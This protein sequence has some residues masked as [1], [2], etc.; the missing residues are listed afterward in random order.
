MDFSAPITILLMPWGRVGSNMVNRIAVESRRVKVFNEPLT[1]IESRGWAAGKSRDAIW[2]DQE[3]WLRQNL[4]ETQHNCPILLN[5]AAISILRPD[6]FTT[7]MDS[8]NV[9]YL[10]MDRHDVGATALSALRTKEW[11]E[12]GRRIG[13][14][15]NWSIPRDHAVDFRP[16]L[17]I[18]ELSDYV[19]IVK[20]GRD[21]SNFVVGRHNKITYYYEDILRDLEGV[22]IDI[23]HRVGVGYYPFTVSSR[24]F[25]SPFVKRTV[26][27]P[28]EVLEYF[29]LNS[30]PTRL[31]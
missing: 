15:R 14:K 21:I 25:G 12:E 5:L 8:L 20:Q 26:S 7:L 19:G 28:L 23:L 22:M 17:S 11:V 24:R 31:K 30:V 2:E 29:K 6:R 1:G 10:F 18:K 4:T 27:N 9:Q 3:V 16:E 13:E